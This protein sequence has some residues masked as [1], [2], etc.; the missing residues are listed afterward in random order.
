MEPEDPRGSVVEPEEARASGGALAEAK[1]PQTL[2]ELDVWLVLRLAEEI[3]EEYEFTLITVE[4]DGNVEANF[5][6][7]IKDV[8]RKILEEIEEIVSEDLQLDLP[9]TNTLHEATLI[10]SDDAELHYIVEVKHNRWIVRHVIPASEAELYTTTEEILSTILP[11][12][13][14]ARGKAV[15]VRDIIFHQIAINRTQ[16][17]D[18]EA[19]LKFMLGESP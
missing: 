11:S 16:I 5:Y 6:N 19:E 17:K 1:P 10:T 4:Q 18:I 2:E 3:G 13:L 15:R 8:A 7:D 14:H 12:K 9:R